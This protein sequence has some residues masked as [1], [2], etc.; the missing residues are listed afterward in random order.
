MISAATFVQSG[1][2]GFL[3]GELDLSTVSILRDPP[4]PAVLVLDLA[5]VRFVDSTGMRELMAL[6]LEAGVLLVN[7]SAA[8]LHIIDVLGLARHIF[9]QSN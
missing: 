4:A 9:D 8:V 6:H 2:V 3:E 7:P 5:G 1:P